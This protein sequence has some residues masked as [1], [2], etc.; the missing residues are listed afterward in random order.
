MDEDRT[1]LFGHPRGLPF[2]VDNRLVSDDGIRL[3]NSK[4]KIATSCMRKFYWEQYRGLKSKYGSTALRYGN[5]YHEC[6]R[7]YYQGVINHG[8]EDQGLLMNLGVASARKQWDALTDGKIF[9]QDYR[10]FENCMELFIGYLGTYAEDRHYIEI[11][12]TEQAFTIP[13]EM[14]KSEEMRYGYLPPIPS[15]GKIDLQ[16]KMRGV[17]WIL[18]FKT[19][20]YAISVV[21]QGLAKSMQ[22]INYTWAA[23]AALGYM[24][25][26]AMTSIVFSSARKNKDGVYG[27]LSTDYGR[28]P[29][30]YTAEDIAQWRESYLATVAQIFDCYSHNS[31]PCNFDSCYMYNKQCPFFGLCMQPVPLDEVNTDGFDVEFWDVTEEGD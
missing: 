10:T 18:D 2:L 6:M 21:S 28:V 23:L 20:S 30:I 29:V 19:T 8:W 16:M 13:F 27:K 11:M 31:W 4:R 3:D 17:P 15:T 5:V 7:G 22:L 25:E 12:A 14:T 1:S 24:P 9:Y 26:G